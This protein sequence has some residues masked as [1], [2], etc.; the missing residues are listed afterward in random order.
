[1]SFRPSTAPGSAGPIR[2]NGSRVR[3]SDAPTWSA[4]PQPGA[5]ARIGGALPLDQADEWAMRRARVTMLETIATKS[6]KSLRQPA[7]RAGLTIR[8]TDDPERLAAHLCLDCR[9]VQPASWR[10]QTK[11]PA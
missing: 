8:I 2:S 11:E 3:S 10:D 7:G 1:M 6:G 5:I 9:S 4:S